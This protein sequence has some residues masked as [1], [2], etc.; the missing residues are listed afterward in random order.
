MFDARVPV[1]AHRKQVQLGAM[2]LWVRSLASPSGLGAGLAVSC[3]VGHRYGLEDDLD[4]PLLKL[5][6]RPAAVAPI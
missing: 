6:H 2:R 4:P 5:W 3:G 1:M